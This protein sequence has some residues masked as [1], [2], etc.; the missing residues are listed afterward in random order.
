MINWTTAG[1]Q[2]TEG[3]EDELTEAFKRVEWH[4]VDIGRTVGLMPAMAIEEIIRQMNRKPLRYAI[5]RDVA[6]YGLLGVE[7]EYKNAIVKSFW[8]DDGYNAI[9]LASEPEYKENVVWN[10]S[11]ESGDSHREQ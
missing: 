5:S 3:K 9:C 2:Y 4:S 7:F 6:P 11:F 1:K 10:R 8:I